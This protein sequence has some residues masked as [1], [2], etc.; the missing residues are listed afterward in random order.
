MVGIGKRFA[1]DENGKTY[2]VPSDM[3][4]DEWKEKAAK[5]AADNVSE[6]NWNGAITRSVTQAEKEEIIDYAK[7]KG[8]NLGDLSKFDGD[9]DL[10]KAEIDTLAKLNTRFLTNNKKLTISVGRLS[11]SDFAETKGNTIIFNTKVLR[12]R[13]ITEKN[14]RLVKG[15]F[16]SQK[17]ED[18]AAHEFGHI[19][20]AKKGNI[21]I[22]ISRKAY[23]NIFGEDITVNEMLEYLDS[24]I[25]QYST[26]YYENANNRKHKFDV[27]RYREVIPEIFARDNSCPNDFTEEFVKLLKE[28]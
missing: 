8:I 10:L 19:F 15:E 12:N 3:T 22:D 18:I 4:Y 5:M 16:A 9:S 6:N 11:D 20:S 24:E 23:Y 1:R 27:K 25:S 14:I 26:T 21:G 2:T 28:V 13:E 7:Q 17:L